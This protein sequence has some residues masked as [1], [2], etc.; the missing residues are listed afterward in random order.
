MEKHRILKILDYLFV[1]RPTLFFPIWTIALVGAYAAKRYTDSWEP[2]G[3]WYALIVFVLYTLTIG[4]VYL[5]NNIIDRRNDEVNNKVFLIADEYIPPARA[6]IYLAALLLTIA[7]LSLL[8][9]QALFWWFTA[10]FLIL[11]VFYS[12]KPFSLK[13]R[14]MGGILTNVISGFGLF[15][16]GWFLYAPSENFQV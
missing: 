12:V 5:I 4:A 2:L 7:I 1:L 16:F 10:M 15:A 9:S 3:F 11:G 6:L 13:D 14:P 8:V